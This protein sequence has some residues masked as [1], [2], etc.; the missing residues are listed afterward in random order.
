M[1]SMLRFFVSCGDHILL[2]FGNVSWTIHGYPPSKTE[3]NGY[4]DTPY[5][6]YTETIIYTDYIGTFL[7]PSTSKPITSNAHKENSY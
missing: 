4:P 1:P 3:A 6:E 5:T 7:T 2:Y